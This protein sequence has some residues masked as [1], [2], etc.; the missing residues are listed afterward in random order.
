MEWPRE[1]R[2][3]SKGEHQT[4]TYGRGRSMEFGRCKYGV[5]SRKR[6]QIQ[7]EK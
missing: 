7:S 4:T 6:Q 5:V 3:A 2:Y 1:G